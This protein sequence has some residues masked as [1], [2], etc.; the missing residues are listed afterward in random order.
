MSKKEISDEITEK[1]LQWTANGGA[2]Q[3]ADAITHRGVELINDP[4]PTR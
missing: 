1:S 2:A 4:L 3:R